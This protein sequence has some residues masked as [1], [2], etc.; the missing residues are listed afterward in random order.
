VP[1]I[2]RDNVKTVVNFVVARSVSGVIVT[3]LHQNVTTET[4]MQN[5]QL[6]IGAYVVGSMVADRAQDHVEK[7]IDQIATAIE[8]V[9]QHIPQ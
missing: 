3:A 9:K 5:L 2:T 7:T 8:T 4:R 6:Y 1:T